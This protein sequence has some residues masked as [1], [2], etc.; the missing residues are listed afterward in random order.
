MRRWWFV[1]GAAVLV[2]V[3]A[4]VQWVVDARE[5]AAVA[6]L[7][8]VPGVLDPLGD[9]LE[10]VRAL[11]EEETRSL[12]TSIPVADQTWASIRV[13]E[14]G[15]QAFTA[16]DLRTGEAVWSTPL[17][18]PNPGRAAGRQKSSGGDASRVPTPGGA[19]TWAVCTVTDGYSTFSVAAGRGAVPATTT[20]VAVLDTGDGHLLADWAVEHDARSACCRAWCSSVSGGTGTSRSSRTTPAPGSSAGAT[21]TRLPGAGPV[22][23]GSWSFATAGDVVAYR[24]GDRLTVLS[25][26]GEVVRTDLQA[27]P[28][29]TLYTDLGTGLPALPSRPADSGDLTARTTLLARDADPARDRVLLGRILRSDRRRRERARPRADLGATSCTRGTRRPAAAGGTATSRGTGSTRSWCGAA[30]S[31]AAGRRSSRSTADAGSRCGRPRRRPAT[32]SGLTT[33]GQ[34]LLVRLDHHRHHRAGRLTGYD[35]ATG[36]V[37]RRFGLPAGIVQLGPYQGQLLGYSRTFEE[38]AVLE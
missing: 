11:G 10:V 24:D 8:A 3:L 38:V 30:S 37:T 31:C 32:Y 20:R 4:G 21:R 22:P 25:A 15:S 2:L 26:S 7:A 27:V 5:R 36:E 16:T 23:A 17:L 9:E 18:G 28:G 13:G 6:R 14:D 29:E 12:L 33:D 35:F 1:A 19:V 34:D